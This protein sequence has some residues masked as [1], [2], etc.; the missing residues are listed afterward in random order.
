MLQNASLRGQ[1]RRLSPGASN[2]HLRPRD[3][4][5]NFTRKRRQSSLSACL[6]LVTAAAKAKP[7]SVPASRVVI[8]TLRLLSSLSRHVKGRRGK[9]SQK[10]S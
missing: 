2:A 5:V 9:P 3:G 4:A 1:N 10:K 7:G 8:F 6:N